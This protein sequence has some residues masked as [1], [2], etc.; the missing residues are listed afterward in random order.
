MA[1]PS[2]ASDTFGASDSLP[3]YFKLI[4]EVPMGDAP[5]F[6]LPG[7]MCV[8]P[9]RRMLPIGADAVVMLELHTVRAGK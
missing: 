6:E 9:H 5:A 3:A 8:D 7:S 2:D 1:M 4:G